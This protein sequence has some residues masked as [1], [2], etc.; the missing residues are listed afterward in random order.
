MSINKDNTTIPSPSAT[1]LGQISNG[2]ETG[3]VLPDAPLVDESRLSST[4]RERRARE[5]QQQAM[6]TKE[7]A[8][9][10]DL[11]AF[12]MVLFGGI[13][14]DKEGEPQ[15]VQDG[16]NDPQ[17]QGKIADA[18]GI[19]LSVFTRTVADVRTGKTSVYEAATRTHTIIDPPR[20]DW[21]KAADVKLGDLVRRDGP[22]LLNEDL[23]KKMQTD[24]NVRQMVQWTF[25]AAEKHGLDAKLLANQYWAES[26]FNPNAVGP[27]TQYGQAVGL[28]QFL[29]TTGKQY[30]LMNESD[31]RD[32]KKAIFAGAHHMADMTRKHGSQSLALVAYNGGS[33]A[34]HFAEKS[35]GKDVTV[36]EWMSFMDNERKT[37]GT[38]DA[39]G[40]K[41]DNLWRVQSFEYVAKIDSAYWSPEKYAKAAAKQDSILREQFAMGGR[42]QTQK[43]PAGLTATHTHTVSTGGRT[44]PSTESPVV[45]AGAAAPTSTVTPA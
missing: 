8:A 40:K 19:D 15:P 43:P 30:G 42:D 2:P 22:T 12:L 34:V 6:M 26:N 29:P 17:T 7:Q 14:K 37:K 45:T 44:K 32:P 23:L 9:A 1:V 10:A 28:A 3:F 16:L 4:E 5:R 41:L 39:K 35:L 25:E 20:V 11:F 38:H 31:L 33:G 21:S 18:L 13:K 36:A 24:A 27:R